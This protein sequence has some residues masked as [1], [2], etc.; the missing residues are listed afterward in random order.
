[1][2]L[3]FDLVPY[4]PRN[5]DHVA[6]VY[7]TFRRST[8]HWPWN[9][10][11]RPMLQ[12]RLRQ[13]LATPGTDTRIATPHGMPDSFLGWYSVRKPDV[14][15]FGFTKYSSRRQAVFTQALMAMGV[16][17]PVY[18]SIGVV[19]W[20]AACARMSDRKG[21]TQWRLYFATQ[22]AYDDDSQSR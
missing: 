11:S 1:M 19:F 15:V 10:M 18:D 21:H 4:D 3:P 17:W 16:L 8:D 2:T 9:A 14:I 6:Y 20:T 22:G 7:D 13:E 5:A 12:E